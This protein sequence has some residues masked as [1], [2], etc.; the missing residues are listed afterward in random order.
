MTRVT[1]PFRNLSLTFD[2]SKF[3][4]EKLAAFFEKNCLHL[5]TRSVSS[6]WFVLFWSHGLGWFSEQSSTWWSKL[7]RERRKKQEY[8]ILFAQCLPSVLTDT[9]A[10]S[11]Y[12]V[13]DPSHKAALL[14]ASY[15][16]ERLPICGVTLLLHGGWCRSVHLF[17]RTANEGTLEI[18]NLEVAEGPKEP[19][20]AG[21]QQMLH[22][23]SNGSLMCQ[24]DICWLNYLHTWWA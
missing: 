5:G 23:S 15:I 12:S 14:Q 16:G 17:S 3:H 6:I 10:M 1:S 18:L 2:D 19:R 24:C 4:R 22:R 13:G 7:V 21:G 11:V 9:S 8:R 20:A